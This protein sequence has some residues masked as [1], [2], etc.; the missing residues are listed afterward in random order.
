MGGS[1]RYMKGMMKLRALLTATAILMVA[2]GGTVTISGA[3]LKGS[4]AAPAELK[5][6]ANAAAGVSD[7]ASHPNSTDMTPHQVGRPGQP[8]QSARPGLVVPANDDAVVARDRCTLGST[9]KRPQ[10]M[11]A[12][13]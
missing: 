7:V 4:S 13:S 9:G 3:V 10:P 12:P 1:E 11:C 8:V 2:C 5:A 6:G